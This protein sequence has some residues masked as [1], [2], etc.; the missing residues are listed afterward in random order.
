MQTTDSR[1]R[2]T[3]TRPRPNAPKARGCVPVK[4]PGSIERLVFISDVHAHMEPLQALER[5]LNRS[6]LKTQ[7]VVVGDIVCGGP[8]P[9]PTIQWVRE[10]SRRLA[11]LGNHDEEVLGAMKPQALPMS[12]AWGRICLNAKDIGYLASLP[13]QI[14][15]SWRDHTIDVLHGHRTRSGKNVSWRSR[16]SQLFRQFK[17]DRVDVTVTGHTH[18]PFVLEQD[19]CRVANCGSTCAVMLAIQN[20]QGQRISHSDDPQFRKAGKIFSSFVEVTTTRTGDL[21]V[22]V[23]HFD[24]DRKQALFRR[25]Q[26]GDPDLPR[27]RTLITQGM[28]KFTNTSYQYHHYK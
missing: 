11:V 15:L 18:Y 10:H 12:D 1:S 17:D 4:I 8:D 21:S 6:K 14:R 9:A 7:V 2:Q 22:R 26:M 13:E 16:P 20:V 27:C 5:I 28:L 3:L 24:Y 23:V 19:D 25:R